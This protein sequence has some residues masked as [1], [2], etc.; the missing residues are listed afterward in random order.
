MTPEVSRA[1]ARFIA[2]LTLS[3]EAA[4]ELAA[5]Y[6]DVN[7]ANDLPDW[8]LEIESADD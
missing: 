3:R 7:D 6:A 2:S 4:R 1:L 8:L 5:E